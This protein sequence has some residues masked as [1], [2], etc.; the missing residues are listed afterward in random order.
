MTVTVLYFLPASHSSAG[1]LYV[2]LLCLSQ[3]ISIPKIG[4]P[5]KVCDNY[6]VHILKL[7]LMAKGLGHIAVATVRMSQD[8]EKVGF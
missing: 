7:G 5:Y 3:N 4:P 1:I 8:Y 2:S 6:V